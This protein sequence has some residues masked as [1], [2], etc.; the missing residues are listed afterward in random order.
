MADNIKFSNEPVSDIRDFIS[1]KKYSR[2]FVLTDDNT[3]KYC[4]PLI[5]DSLPP[6]EVTS[7]MSGEEHKNL[8]TC[9]AIWEKMT[10]YQMDRHSLML[11]LG[12]GVLGDMGGFCAATY[13]RGIDFMLIPTTLLSQVDSS[14]G[15]KLGIDFNNYKNHIGVFQIPACTL[16][17]SGFLKTLPETELRSGFA[18]IIKH[19]IIS[20]EA[21]WKKIKGKSLHEQ[22]WDELIRHSVEFKASVT[23]EDPKEKGLRKILNTGHTIGHAIETFLLSNDR[24][25]THGEAIAA[26]MIAENFISSKQGMLSSEV[27]KEIE[28]LIIS[29]YGKLK[30]HADEFSKIALL[31]LQ[32][33]KNKEN[34][35]LSV[36]LE[37]IGK[38]RWDCEI[39]LPS[40]EESLSYYESL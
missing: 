38:P 30:L 4:Y 22:D 25:V 6:H 33:K 32:D 26:G 11:I 21:M 39:T 34:K 19:V 3:L 18:E 23:K 29:I 40:I 1:N 17:Y 20:D 10:S 28:K 16:L 9:S 24:K 5:K 31:T 27:R 8:Q 7:V 35:V 15:G 12:G 2:I 14:I 36:L 37:S 13:K